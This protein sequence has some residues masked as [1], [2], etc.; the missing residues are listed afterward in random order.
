M[1]ESKP[2]KAPEAKDPR[3][4]LRLGALFL[5]IASAW[6]WAV[7]PS[8][9]LPQDWADA[10]LGLFFG[11]SIACF[12]VSIVRRRKQRETPPPVS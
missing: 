11:V 8:G 12:I 6:K 3:L 10:S 7:R 1:S 4:P 5:L 2:A 9:V